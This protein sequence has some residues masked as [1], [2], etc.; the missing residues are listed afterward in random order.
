MELTPEF[1]QQLQELLD[2]QAI[3]D[4]LARYARGLDRVSP[5]IADTAFHDVSWDYHGAFSG[6][7]HDFLFNAPRAEIWQSDANVI[8]HHTMATSTIT[9][10]GDLA[11]SE[12]YFIAAGIRVAD[13]QRR[14]YQMWGRY[15]DKFERGEGGWRIRVRKAVIDL[16]AEWPEGDP[17]VSEPD[18]P[19]GGRWPDD[20]VFTMAELKAP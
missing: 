13:G 2:K 19:K 9:V 20:E 12:T 14:M 4:T 5:E 17:W 11:D 3:R 7:G 1:V 8:T 6:S 18:Y 15:L 16:S 10:D